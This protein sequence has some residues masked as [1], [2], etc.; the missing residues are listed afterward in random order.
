MAKDYTRLSR[1]EIER[2]IILMASDAR[3]ENVRRTAIQ[4]MV[5]YNDLLPTSLTEA[6]FSSAVPNLVGLL[7]V[8]IPATP[9][10]L[11]ALTDAQAVALAEA[12]ELATWDYQTR[13]EQLYQVEAFY[14]K[15]GFG[16]QANAATNIGT[17]R[18]T[19]VTFMNYA[20]AARGLAALS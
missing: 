6:Q 12:H 9:A 5:R 3:V 2:D 11:S 20:R 8:A 16:G 18:A 1:A 17:I 14:Q 7:S 13:A 4:A 19:L 10:D 15:L